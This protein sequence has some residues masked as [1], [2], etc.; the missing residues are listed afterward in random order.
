[1][2]PRTSPVAESAPAIHTVPAEARGFQGERAG[3][4]SR[5][6]ANS[7]DFA[8]L[9]VILGAIYF[10]WSA[11][12][13]LRQ[14]PAFQFPTV[15]YADVYVA[16]AIVFSL[17]FA[18]FWWGTGRTYGDHVLGLRVLNRHGERL[19]PGMSILRAVLCVHF[20]FLL[21]WAVVNNRSVQD[22]VLRTSVIY[23]WQSSPR[24]GK[25]GADQITRSSEE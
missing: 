13:F 18:L 10:G 3:I 14:G 2:E 6:L 7:I 16:G 19:G 4:V 21:F 11:V 1:M 20:P 8:V 22:V 15:S 25:R 12:L 5:V 9:L 24:R 23:D 17:Y